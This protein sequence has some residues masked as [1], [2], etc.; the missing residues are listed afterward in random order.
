[1][2]NGLTSNLLQVDCGVPQGSV[3]GPMLFLLFINDLGSV[4]K[5]SKYKLYE[6][7]TVLY[8]DCTG[9]TDGILKTNIQ[10]DLD[11]VSTWCKLNDIILNMK[12]TK[13]M[14]F[15]TRHKLSQLDPLQIHVNGRRL[16]CVPSYKYLGTFVDSELNFIKQSNKTIKPV[17]YKFYFLGRNVT[18]TRKSYIQPYFD[19]NDDS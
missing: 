6:D 11:H 4:T 12:K 1:M 7:D 3:L 2:A 18:E 10:H 14:M 19:Y 16:E 9:E 8:S 15:G 13:T 17:S 5:H